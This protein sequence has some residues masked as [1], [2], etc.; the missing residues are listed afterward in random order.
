[1][2]GLL[3]TLVLNA[4]KQCGTSSVENVVSVFEEQITLAQAEQVRGFLKWAFFDWENRSFGHGNFRL[5]W[6]QWLNTQA[7]TNRLHQFEW[8]I[9]CRCGASIRGSFGKLMVENHI[10]DIRKFCEAHQKC[11]VNGGEK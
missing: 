8:M 11:K 5:R 7:K 3:Q 4:V 2:T 6:R 1:M 10:I 9:D